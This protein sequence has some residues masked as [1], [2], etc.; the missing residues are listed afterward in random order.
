MHINWKLCW[1]DL[2]LM[3]L[4]RACASPA[5]FGSSRLVVGSSRASMPQLRQKVSASARRITIAASTF[6]PAEQRPRMSRGTSPGLYR[7][8]YGSILVVSYYI[9]LRS[10]I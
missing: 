8:G 6:W 1:E 9:V 2:D 5:L 4:A 7:I 3:I 10:S